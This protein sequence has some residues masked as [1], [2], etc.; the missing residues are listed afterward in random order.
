MPVPPS[1]KTAPSVRRVAAGNRRSGR[2][3]SATTA[4]R[5]Y[6]DLRSELVSLQ[7]RPGEAISE[8]EIALSFGVSRTPVREAILKLSDE[9]L[10]EIYPQ[11]GIFVSRIPIDALPEAIIIRK[12]LE[13]TTARLAAER[14]TSSQVLALRAILERQREASAAGDSETFHQTDE[15]FHATVAE[16]AGYPGIWK[17]I[18]QVKVHVD[19]YRRLTLPQ[20]GRIPKVITEHEAVLTA[21]EAHDPERA[22]RAMEAHLENLLDNI[23]ATQHINPEFFDQRR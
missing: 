2:P 1:K 5:I 3:R 23:S 9:G 21:I 17:F 20:L 13:E 15:L 10:L 14:A 4:S 19:R 16:V 12:A 18:Q 8:A 22:R 11:S 6:S 7:R